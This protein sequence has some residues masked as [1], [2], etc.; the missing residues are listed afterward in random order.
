MNDRSGMIDEMLRLSNELLMSIDAFDST[1]GED[2][3][4]GNE[5]RIACI[6]NSLLDLDG[7]IGDLVP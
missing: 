5:L 1:G 7:D 3:D 6:R 2:S 4:E